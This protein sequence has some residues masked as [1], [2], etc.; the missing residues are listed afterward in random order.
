MDR[1]HKKIPPPNGGR[2]IKEG[3]R[4][5]STWHGGGGRSKDY[6]RIIHSKRWNALR[7]AYIAEHP[8][9]EDCMAAGILDQKAEEVHHIRPIGMGRDFAGMCALAFDPHNLRSLCHACHV[10]AHGKLRRGRT[11]TDEGM[12]AWLRQFL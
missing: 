6:K 8:F 2:A 3:W 4:S 12:E 11:T 10:R 7:T 5:R 9:C 1:S